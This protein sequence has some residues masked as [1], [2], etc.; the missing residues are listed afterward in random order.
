MEA[1]R[2]PVD[3][4]HC[5]KCDKWHAI[6]SAAKENCNPTA[7]PNCGWRSSGTSEPECPDT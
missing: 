7:C 6:A 3:Q 5:P 4:R 1:P 2:E